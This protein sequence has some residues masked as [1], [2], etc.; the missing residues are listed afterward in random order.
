VKKI[1]L[2][3]LVLV[4]LQACA[5]DTIT[6]TGPVTL[7]YSQQQAFDKWRKGNTA[8]D[9]LYFFLRKGGGSYRVYCPDSV[10]IC[11]EAT[12][13]KWHSKCEEKY[14]TGMCKLY[15]VWGGVVW[16]QDQPADPNWGNL[17]PETPENVVSTVRKA[18]CPDGS[19]DNGKGQCLVT[20][21]PIST[22]C[23]S[24]LNGRL[25]YWTDETHRQDYVKEAKRRGISLSDCRKALGITLEK[26]KV[27]PSSS[28]VS[29]ADTSTDTGQRLREL[30]KLLEEGLITKEEA[31]VKRKEILKNL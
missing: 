16:K 29:P 9:P 3:A 5:P 24:A 14:G 20:L 2:V 30:K 31:A 19:I 17:Y 18:D 28:K 25:S 4:L 27:E 13:F 6:G 22:L 11:K 12:E 1:Q 23:G 21:M 10:M 8:K 15:G 7:T 26:T